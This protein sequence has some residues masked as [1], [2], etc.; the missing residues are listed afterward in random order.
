[1]AD[2]RDS[3]ST[4]GATLGHDVPGGVIRWAQ[5]SLWLMM[6]WLPWVGAELFGEAQRL[7]QLYPGETD[8]AP[9]YAVVGSI[10]LIAVALVFIGIIWL[11]SLVRDN[12]VFTEAALRWANITLGALWAITALAIFVLL[13]FLT[14]G[15][16]GLLGVFGPREGG[17]GAVILLAG[18][19]GVAII[20]TLL[21][22]VMRSLLTEAITNRQELADV[23]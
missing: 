23:I 18:L 22:M 4:A 21:M 20:F 12:R 17:A 15:F 2:T 8:F 14:N 1:M 16:F 6:F 7:V 19:S 11:L 13:D 10:A 9:F 5:I 3:L